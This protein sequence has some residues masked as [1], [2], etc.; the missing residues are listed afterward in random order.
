MLAKEV[1]GQYGFFHIDSHGGLVAADMVLQND[2]KVR[3]GGHEL[4]AWRISGKELVIEYF[5]KPWGRAVLYP[6]GNGGFHGQNIHTNGAK[7]NWRL[8]SA[9]ST[10]KVAVL[11]CGHMRSFKATAESLRR[12]VLV[13]NNADLFIST[14]S[15]RGLQSYKEANAHFEEGVTE[16]KIREVYGDCLKGVVIEHEAPAKFANGFHGRHDPGITSRIWSMWYKIKMCEEVCRQY[17]YFNDVH[18]DILIRVRPDCNFE[19]TILASSY[20]VPETIT[21]PF[22]EGYGGCCDQFALGCRHEM[23]LYCG[24]YDNFG[25]YMGQTD[26]SWAEGLMCHHMFRSKL[27]VCRANIRY[28]RRR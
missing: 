10:C 12:H 8:V 11:L 21:I 20:C 13:P 3:I 19:H 2:A 23:G 28:W 4:A 16:A 14:W 5:H 24:L 18:Y 25:H 17:E 22:I 7:Y 1:A 15:S 9:D 26:V 27:S 6:H